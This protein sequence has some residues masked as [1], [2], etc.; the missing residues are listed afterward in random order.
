MNHFCKV[1]L[2]SNSVKSVFSAGC[3]FRWVYLMVLFLFFYSYLH[4]KYSLGLSNCK[5][6]L[7]YQQFEEE[8]V[9]KHEIRISKNITLILTLYFTDA[10][11]NMVKN[12]QRIPLDVFINRLHL[13][14][15][16]GKTYS[17]IS[18]I[19]SHWKYSKANICMHVK[20]NIGNLVVTKE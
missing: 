14:Q 9:I 10:F 18:K 15:D 8:L 4:K 13:H 1:A 12:L 2:F 5:Y 20:K 7:F 6:L 17:E 11:I 3:H 16:A 19:R